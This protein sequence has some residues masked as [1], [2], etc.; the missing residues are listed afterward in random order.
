MERIFLSL[1]KRAIENISFA[2]V[3]GMNICFT[4]D[5]EKLIR[6]PPKIFGFSYKISFKPGTEAMV[7]FCYS[8]ARFSIKSCQLACFAPQDGAFHQLTYFQHFSKFASLIFLLF[9]QLACSHRPKISSA[10]PA[11]LFENF[12]NNILNMQLE[13]ASVL[14]L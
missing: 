8:L 5:F 1:A 10:R 11:C 2:S 14:G 9:F 13:L 6:V 7:F 3:Y 12:K 4:R